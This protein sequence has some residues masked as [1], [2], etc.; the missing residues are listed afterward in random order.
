M[1]VAQGYGKNHKDVQKNPYAFLIA[2]RRNKIIKY[3]S[4]TFWN[5]R[6]ETAQGN[7]TAAQWSKPCT[8]KQ[9]ALQDCLISFTHL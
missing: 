8:F 4:W 5:A 7:F 9:A 2:L 1:A 6:Q 3:V